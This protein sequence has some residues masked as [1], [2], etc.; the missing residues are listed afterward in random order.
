MLK[1]QSKESC[2]FLF[3]FSNQSISFEQFS[4]LLFMESNSSNILIH[5]K[6]DGNKLYFLGWRCRSFHSFD[7][8]L[9]SKTI[10]FLKSKSLFVLLL[11]EGIGGYM[12]GT[13]GSCFPSS[14]V[15]WRI[16]GVQLETIVLII[17]GKE[18]GRTKRPWT[19]NLSVIL[20][21]ITNMNNQF[22]NGYIGSVLH[23]VV[24]YECMC[25]WAYSLRRL[26]R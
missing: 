3:V 2:F 24:L 15:P 7:Q 26:I 9:Q 19:S 21:D 20:F 11:E 25:T 23:S 16:S 14:V 13:N 10:A 18:E 8:S 5:V 12:V 6:S 1:W 17:A 4:D 22:F